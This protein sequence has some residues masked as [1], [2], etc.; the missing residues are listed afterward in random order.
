MNHNLTC[1]W[2]RDWHQCSCGALELQ[3]IVENKNLTLEPDSSELLTYLI[4]P[5]GKLEFGRAK[6]QG[7]MQVGTLPLIARIDIPKDSGLYPNGWFPITTHKS[8]LKVKAEIERDDIKDVDGTK[9][10]LLPQWLLLDCY[11]HHWEQLY[12]E[13]N[14]KL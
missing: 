4:Y 3:L 1:L 6:Y 7:G 9:K 12:H 11:A 13:K 14:S 2:H 10:H 8:F 5:K